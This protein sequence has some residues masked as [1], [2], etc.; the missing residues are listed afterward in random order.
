MSKFES[1][2]QL[3]QKIPNAKK[4]MKNKNV[5][6]LIFKV[7]ESNSA[8]LS[9]ISMLKIIFHQM[10]AFQMLNARKLTH[11]RDAEI[12]ENIQNLIIFVSTKTYSH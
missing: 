6:T 7:K 12:Q 10:S 8:C 5:P 3:A 4:K 9:K 1:H 2:R 11:S